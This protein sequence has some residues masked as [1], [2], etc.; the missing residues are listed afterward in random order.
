MNIVDQE[1][2]PTIPVERVTE[3]PDNPRKGD[4]EAV[5]KSIDRNGFFGAII[6]QRSTGHVIAG[7]TRYRAM[8]DGGATTIPGFWVDCDDEL[9]LR[10]M[11]ADNR[12][13]DLAFYDDEQL[14]ILL[15]QLVE[16]EGLEGTGYDRAAYELLLQSIEADSIVGGIRQGV[17]PEERIDAYNEIG[18]RSIVLPYGE[19]DYEEVANAFGILRDLFNL[20]DNA[21]VA[22][23][24]VLDAVNSIQY[25]DAAP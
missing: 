9:A 6:I 16:S 22:R 19:D 4:D 17:V 12:T 14:F 23:R 18:I 24:L 20:E 2:D 5:T 7:N 8:R 3:H 11:L 10:I 21:A 13:S 25:E 15:K 1:F